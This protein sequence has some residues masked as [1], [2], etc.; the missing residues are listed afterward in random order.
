MPVRL[1]NTNA[2]RLLP[3]T[4]AL[5]SLA[6]DG[7]ASATFNTI[8]QV[9][10]GV[11][12][13]PGDTNLVTLAAAVGGTWVPNI[14]TLTLAGNATAEVKAELDL[15]TVT[16]GLDTI[17]QAQIAGV[18]GNDITITVVG[19]SAPAGGVT[20]DEV[21]NAVTIHF[22]DGVSTVADVETAIGAESDLIEVKTTGTGATVLASPADECTDES[23]ALG[24]TE[25]VT[26]GSTV[27][28]WRDAGNATRAY[29]VVIAGSASASI[30]NLIAAINANGTGDGTDYGASTVV[31]P[32]VRAYA[33]AGDTMDVHTNSNTILTAVGTLIATTEDMAAGSWGAATLAD[34]TDG[35][36]VTFSVSGYDITCTFADGYSTVSDFEAALAADAD[37]SALIE[38]D[39]AGTTP[40]YRLVLTDDDF[41]ATAFSGGGATSAA[42]PTL[43]DGTAGA[44]IPICCD[45]ALITVES[46]AGSGAMTA[47]IIIWGWSLALSKW[48]VLG[49]LNAG[50]AIGETSANAINYG[51]LVVGLR[52]IG[53]LYAEISGALGGTGTELQIYADCI[54]ATAVTH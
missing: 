21:G 20:I 36:N 54:P 50:A 1:R 40:L 52:H 44:Q 12:E 31:H 38:V 25:T 39:T 13:Q 33:G 24:A 18:E 4:D 7:P 8:L 17:V 2:I 45:Q 48:F 5:A 3:T 22:E 6:V 23:L 16:G 9:K 29:D 15:D 26:I 32:T 27:Y 14:G 28:S 43:N 19:D 42:A 49:T 10:A 35:T 30:D 47:T 11:F 53:R 46:V 51:E 41:S 37:V 34:G